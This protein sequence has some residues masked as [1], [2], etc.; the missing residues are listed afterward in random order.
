MGESEPGSC[1]TASHCKT[2]WLLTNEFALKDITNTLTPLFRFGPASQ[3]MHRLLRDQSCPVI[4]KLQFEQSFDPQD[5][6]VGFLTQD[7]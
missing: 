7:S 6:W 4:A 3:T 2:H 5:W 1:P